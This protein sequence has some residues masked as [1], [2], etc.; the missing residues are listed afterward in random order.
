MVTDKEGPNA[1]WRSFF[2]RRTTTAEGHQDDTLIQ[3]HLSALRF[4][5]GSMK[6]GLSLLS[7][8]LY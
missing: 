1:G 7:N 2:L 6:L 4:R 8:L 5:E 3:A